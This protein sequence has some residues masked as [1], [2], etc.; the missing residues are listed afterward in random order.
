MIADPYENKSKKCTKC[1]STDLEYQRWS[2]GHYGEF[3]GYS[4]NDC[5]NPFMWISDALEA[6]KTEQLGKEV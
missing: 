6:G 5:G 3:E 1:G 2:E 4:C